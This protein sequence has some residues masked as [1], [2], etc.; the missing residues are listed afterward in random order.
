MQ[1]LSK[2][3]R[4]IFYIR[5]IDLVFKNILAFLVQ[6]LPRRRIMGS[7]AILLVSLQETVHAA[8]RSAPYLLPPLQ[9]G[10]PAVSIYN[11]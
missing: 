1:M 2:F 11:L 7:L 3:Y 5:E 4:F 8:L 9:A 6:L 10:G